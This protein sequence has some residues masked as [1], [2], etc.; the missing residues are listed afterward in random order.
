MPRQAGRFFPSGQLAT[1]V[2][3]PAAK[4]SSAECLGSTTNRPLVARRR[5]DAVYRAAAHA[6]D[7]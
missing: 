7:A 1:D 5:R 6:S 2:D 4:V 3:R